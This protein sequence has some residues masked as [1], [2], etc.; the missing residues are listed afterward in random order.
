LRIFFPLDS[1][2]L[3]I[4]GALEEIPVREERGRAFPEKTLAE[5]EQQR[6]VFSSDS[7]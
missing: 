3:D 4:V 5:P 6:A 7:G 2:A 1:D